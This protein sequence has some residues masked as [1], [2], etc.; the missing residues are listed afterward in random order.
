[1]LSIDRFKAVIFDFDGVIIDS[2]TVQARAWGALAAE[3]GLAE[4]T[5]SIGQIAGKL[6][7]HIAP[8][9]FPTYDPAHCVR[10]KHLIQLEME[11]Q[12]GVFCIEETLEFARRIGASHRLAICSS[13]RAERI[14][15]VLDLH[16]M[17]PC[18]E[19]IVG[20]LPGEECKP[21]PAPYLKTLRL[22]SLPPADAC[23]IEDSP[24]GITAAKA[25]GL[26]TFQLLH[27]GMAPNPHADAVIRSAR[28]LR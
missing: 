20:Q 2:E 23:V 6:D 17:T 11:E 16:N 24:T 10:R 14:R 15:E 7:R 25:A 19:V 9:L 27:D 22:L 12:G 26:F 21:S 4:T 18:F 13:S 8:E 28:E 3:L 5:V 1:M